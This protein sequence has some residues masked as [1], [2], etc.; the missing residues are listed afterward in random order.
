MTRP[1]IGSALPVSRPGAQKREGRQAANQ[2]SKTDAAVLVAV[3]VAVLVCS[4][5]CGSA[6]E[7]ASGPSG[8]CLPSRVPMRGNHPIPRPH[9]LR[10]SKLRNADG[11]TD[12]IAAGGRASSW[13]GWTRASR[14]PCNGRCCRALSSRRPETSARRSL[15]RPPNFATTRR[16]QKPARRRLGFYVLQA[17]DISCFL[18]GAQGLEPWTR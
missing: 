14:R 6:A 12:I 9:E 11:D 7:I 17:T 18:V 3:I 1:G 5:C 2:G 8:G 16:T 4:R 10:R 13:S 15:R